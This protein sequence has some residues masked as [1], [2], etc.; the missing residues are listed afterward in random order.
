VAQ[1]ETVRV[2]GLKELQKALRQMD[3]DVAKELRRELKDAGTVVQQQ[4]IS[5]FSPI[6]AGSALGF[7]VRV[8]QRGVAVEQSKRRT[9][10]LHPE[11]GGLQMR[12]A[13]L[14]ALESNEDAVVAKVE[15]MLD[16]V[17]RKLGF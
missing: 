7:K 15:H 6:S 17:G 1:Q 5:L 9:T 3:A 8:R 4:A 12:R 10:G 14:P 16:T 2:T 11:F 13:L